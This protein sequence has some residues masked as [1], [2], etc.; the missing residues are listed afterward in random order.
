M[1]LL[2]VMRYDKNEQKK[3]IWEGY[4]TAFE[5]ACIY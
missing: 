3:P 5:Q 1:Y 4:K 2:R